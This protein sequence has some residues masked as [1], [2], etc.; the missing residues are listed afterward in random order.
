MNFL[1][2][3]LKRVGLQNF[4]PKNQSKNRKKSLPKFEILRK[5]HEG[6]KD[7]QKER[8]QKE[9]FCLF[10]DCRAY[11]PVLHVVVMRRSRTASCRAGLTVNRVLLGQWTWDATWDVVAYYSW[12]QQSQ[13]GFNFGWKLGPFILAP[14][15]HS[16]ARNK[17]Q[18]RRFLLT[19]VPRNWRFGNW[20]IRNW[21][22][23]KWRIS[24]L[25]GNWQIGKSGTG[26]LELANWKLLNRG[27]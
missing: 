20:W 11:K 23:G 24:S 6:L 9:R 18:L 27:N 5:R 13:L 7:C 15:D 10:W 14:V 3:R 4:K 17:C 25:N 19:I 26:K 21:R 16:P 22:I 1:W 2:Q 8:F 12:G